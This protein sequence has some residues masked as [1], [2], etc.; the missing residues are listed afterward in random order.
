MPAKC[1]ELSFAHLPS[2]D[3][4]IH[5][6]HLVYPVA[7]HRSDSDS[8]GEKEALFME[9]RGWHVAVFRRFGE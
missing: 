4:E 7:H 6:G 5:P 3:R 2:K 8:I 1:L 9:T